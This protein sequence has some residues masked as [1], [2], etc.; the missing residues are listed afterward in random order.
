[1]AYIVDTLLFNL[2][3]NKI[4]GMVFVDYKKAFDVVDHATLL[5]KLEAYNR[6]KNVLLWFRS[7]LI[8]HIQLVSFM[9][10]SS[11]N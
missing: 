11:S 10:Q 7:Y 6:D 5:S 9:G 1:M 3:K 8:D 2:D 4:N